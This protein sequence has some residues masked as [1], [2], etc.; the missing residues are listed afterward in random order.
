MTVVQI[1]PIDH[2]EAWQMPGV[3]DGA[4]LH[5]LYLGAVSTGEAV[6]RAMAA[7]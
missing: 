3:V 5:G 2:L 4:S 1:R 6:P 7:A